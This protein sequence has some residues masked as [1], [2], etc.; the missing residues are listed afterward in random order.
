MKLV[1]LQPMQC[2]EF[3]GQF[4]NYW[5]KWYDVSEDL[6]YE[7]RIGKEQF[8]EDDIQELYEW[9][10]QSDLS[11]A[12]QKSLEEKIL[13]KI[14]C[15]NSLKRNFSMDQFKKEFGNVSAVWKIFLLHI[16]QP[17]IYP[18]Y[19][20]NVH[21][22]YCF[23][24]GEKYGDISETISD[25]RK[26]SFYFNEYLPFINSYKE[27]SDLRTIDRGLFGLGQFLKQMHK[28]DLTL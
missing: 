18:I 15:V 7:D 25:K 14:D 20:Q 6:P 27:Q 12:K 10:N 13:K 11:R 23:I 16:I 21:R 8:E 5:A 1:I 4:I 26:E 9:K 17:E 2:P 19:D 24:H 3:N 22:A 28:T